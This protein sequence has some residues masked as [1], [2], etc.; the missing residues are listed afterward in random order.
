M[1]N[2][3]AS[4]HFDGNKC[5]QRLSPESGGCYCHSFP[6]HNDMS[7][8]IK[9]RDSYLY[10]TGSDRSLSLSRYIQSLESKPELSRY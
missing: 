7:S 8:A 4:C 3:P 2:K 6:E 5:L 9:T 1:I 10:F